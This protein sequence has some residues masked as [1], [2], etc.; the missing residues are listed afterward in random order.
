M[1]ENAQYF[2]KFLHCNEN[3]IYVFLFFAASVPISTFMCLWAILYLIL[4]S[5]SF[6]VCI[7]VSLTT[8]TREFMHSLSYVVEATE[9]IHKEP[10]HLLNWAN[11]SHR[12]LEKHG[13][14]IPKQRGFCASKQGRG[15][16]IG[17]SLTESEDGRC[18]EKT[19][20]TVFVFFF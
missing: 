4:T 12:E 13:Y 15:G 11:I 20:A 19:C 6:A 7:S 14:Y 16:N 18:S 1:L 10:D 17:C 3:P 8:S 9:G 2:L 5:P